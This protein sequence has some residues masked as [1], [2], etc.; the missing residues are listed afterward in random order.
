M[1]SFVH[2][3]RFLLLRLSLS[4]FRPPSSHSREKGP[5][6]NGDHHRQD[7]L[8]SS[9]RVFQAQ[10]SNQIPSKLLV[11]LLNKLNNHRS[12]EEKKANPKQNGPQMVE[13][14][15]FQWQ[16]GNK[17]TD[18]KPGACLPN[19]IKAKMIIALHIALRLLAECKARN[20]I[21][22]STAVYR[23]RTPLQPE[24]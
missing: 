22:E 5:S 8:A 3:L 9:S 16:N 12:G 20:G 1:S 4:D 18:K 15:S 14:C 2:V 24:P 13:K 10:V 21:N 6:Y 7:R 19:I 11:K 17:K 23:A